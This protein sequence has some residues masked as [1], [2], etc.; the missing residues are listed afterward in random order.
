MIWILALLAVI[1]GSLLPFQAGINASLRFALNSPVLAAITNFTVGGSLVVA[2]ALASRTPLPSVSQL[3]R[4]P[5]W[6]W[7]GGVMGACLVFA[8][9]LLSHRLGAAT[10]TACIILGQLTASVVVD[11]FGWV[12]YAQHA[13]SGPR[14]VG[15]LMLLGGAFLIRQ[16]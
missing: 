5:A 8:G 11:H 3:A 15:L 6:C 12:G 2:Y 7:L 16:Y 9:V 14:I 4:V 1:V 13:V 10:F